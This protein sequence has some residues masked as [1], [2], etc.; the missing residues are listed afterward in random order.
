M[1]ISTSQLFQQGIKAVLDQQG[2][3]TKLQLQISTGKRIQSPADDPSGAVRILDL[4]QA[5]DTNTQYQENINLSRQRLEVEDSTLGSTVDVLRRVRE[6]A[7]QG[8][9]DSNSPD[10]RASIAKEIRQRLDD[11]LSLANT[12]DANGE[13]IFS[14]FSSDTRPVTV[15]SDGSFTYQGDQGQR[16]LQVSTTRQVADRDPGSSIFFD[17]ATGNGRFQVQDNAANTGTGIIDTG[18]VTDLAA[19]DG[20]TYRIQFTN[21]A[22]DP[23]APADSYQVLDSAN[24]VEASGAYVPGT[25]IRF[26]GIETNV[27]GAPNHADQF[28]VSPSGAQD[29]FST[30][31]DLALAFESDTGDTQSRTALHNEINRVLNNLGHAEDKLL[32]SR[33]AVGARL[34]AAD[35]QES[36]NEDYTLNLTKTLS[37]IEDLDIAEAASLLQQRMAGLE[38]AQAAFVRVQGLSLFD[39]LK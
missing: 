19:L 6:L 23:T 9:N 30:V 12:Q 3:V 13:Y 32:D 29:I 16:F 10:T 17:V 38:A 18:S 37:S 26:N 28:T 27:T 5:I 25:A 34:N 11:L 20:D 8:N 2:E 36:I 15:E 35:T 14:G 21:L 1:R 33:A 22:G 24:N 39:Y 4:R 7:I 31:R